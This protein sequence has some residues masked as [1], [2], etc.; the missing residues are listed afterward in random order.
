MMCNRDALVLGSA[1]GGGLEP[2]TA[3]FRLVPRIS[4]LVRVVLCVVLVVSCVV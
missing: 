1:S 3:R 2:T 4:L